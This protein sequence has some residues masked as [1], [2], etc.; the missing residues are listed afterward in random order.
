MDAILLDVFIRR[1]SYSKF[2][3]GPCYQ[4]LDWPKSSFG[5]FHMISNEL[6]GQLNISLYHK[7]MPLF[8]YRYLIRDWTRMNLSEKTNMKNKH[9]QDTKNHKARV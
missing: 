5:F 9:E 7:Y 2:T 1:F 8:V 6:F 4:I 3:R